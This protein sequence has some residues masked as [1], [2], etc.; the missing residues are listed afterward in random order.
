VIISVIAVLLNTGGLELLVKGDLDVNR[1]LRVAG[2]ASLAGACGGAPV[3]FQG[4]SDTALAYDLGAR[5]RTPGLVAALF[6]AGTLAAGSGLLIFCPRFLAGGLLLFLGLSFLGEWL[7]DAYKKL[8]RPEYASIVLVAV[9]IAGLG[10]LE[11]VALGLLVAAS[12]FVVQYSRIDV[13][14]HAFTGSELH[15]NVD[16]TPRQA[17]RLKHLGRRTLILYLQGYVFFG[18]AYDLLAK[19]REKAQDPST[20][21]RF[22]VL[23]FRLV[24]GIDSSALHSFFKLRQYAEE[25]SLVLVFAEL[26]DEF[27]QHLERAG[28]EADAEHQ[29]ILQLPDLDRAIEW[30]E[31]RVLSQDQEGAAATEHPLEQ[32]LQTAFGRGER[33]RRF[34]AH[35]ERREVPT[36]GEGGQGRGSGKG[37]GRG[38]QE[39]GQEGGHH[40]KGVRMSP[41]LFQTRSPSKLNSSFLQVMG[42]LERAERGAVAT[43][44]PE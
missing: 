38:S 40:R 21:T 8:Q 37:E 22:V 31:E 13:V 29:G 33:L 25:H 4:M 42:T 17:R 18:T 12:T 27:R 9:A 16:R 11:G 32:I 14:R 2:L 24:T 43:S 1:E 15:S 23:D 26:R 39:G 35:L 36:S 7:V 10:F 19:V 44:I 5:G 28:Y 20:T 41:L 6:Y 34:M 30:C 3:G